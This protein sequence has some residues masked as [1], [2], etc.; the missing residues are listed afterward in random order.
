MARNVCHVSV[1]SETVS[2][3]A[4]S[5]ILSGSQIEEIDQLLLKGI[6]CLYDTPSSFNSEFSDSE[7]LHIEFHG[8]RDVFF[9]YFSN[10][11]PMMLLGTTVP[12]QRRKSPLKREINYICDQCIF[13]YKREFQTSSEDITS[14]WR[15]G[16][17]MSFKWTRFWISN[18]KRDAY[19]YDTKII[20]NFIS[21]S[22]DAF[23]E[24]KYPEVLRCKSEYMQ[25]TFEINYNRFENYLKWFKINRHV[26]IDKLA[27]H[28]QLAYPI[29]SADVW[30]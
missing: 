23:L 2:W 24:L 18:R 30:K 7:P 10:R 15:S 19:Y 11:L 25:Q 17:K 12:W 26:F 1:N 3:L 14:Q 16:Y 22:I 13:R 4:L 6:E 8:L 27:N 9:T 21:E 29:Y 20:E 5:S 28:L